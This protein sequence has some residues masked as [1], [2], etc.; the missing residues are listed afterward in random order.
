MIFLKKIHL[1]GKQKI[2]LFGFLII[3]VSLPLAVLLAK[4][5]QTYQGR[6]ASQLSNMP[7][8]YN[9]PGQGIFNCHTVAAIGPD[10]I[11]G[12]GVLVY[13]G[14]LQPQSPDRLDQNALNKLIS[15]IKSGKKV[16]LHFQ[17]YAEPTGITLDDLYPAWIRSGSDQIEWI[18]TS[19]GPFPAPWSSKYQE[20]LKQFLSLL[21]TAFE[22][23][24]VSHLVEYLEPASGGRWGTTHLWF[25]E[26]DFHNWVAASGCGRTDYT[27]FRNKFSQAVNQIIKVYA[28]SFPNYSLMMIEGGAPHGAGYNGFLKLLEKYGMRVMIKGAGLG[29]R[30]EPHCGMR[31]YILQPACSIAAGN[32]LTKCGQETWGPSID[33]AGPGHGFDPE[34]ECFGGYQEIYE[35]SLR[36][37]K[38][39]YYCFYTT[40]IQCSALGQTNRMVADYL[41]AQI[42]LMN[43]NFSSTNIEIN[44]PLQIN[45]AWRNYGSTAFVAPK[46]LGEKWLAS[47][48]KLF[49]EFVKD[50]QRV[51]Y[52]EFDVSP[53]THTWQPE[54]RRYYSYFEATNALKFNVPAVLGGENANSQNTYKVYVGF[55]DPNGESERFALI[56]QQNNDLQNRRYLLTNNFIVRGE[57]ETPTITPMPTATSSPQ[58]GLSTLTFKIKLQGVT[59]QKPQQTTQVSLTQS[60]ETKYQQD[61]ILTANGEGYYTGQIGNLTP[62][63][64]DVYVKGWAHLQKKFENIQIN[65]G[66]NE[67]VW[68]QTTLPAGD[69]NDD[70]VLDID[71]I[72]L[73]LQQYTGTSVPA[74]EENYQFDVNL[75]GQINVFDLAL[76][77]QNWTDLKVPGE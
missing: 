42:E 22:Q 26:S 40:D 69:F 37:E 35:A 41:G 60:G 72:S 50:N 16:Y 70:N 65:L 46:K 7:A 54:K 17:I 77:L 33:C 67:I 28:D 44:Q 49:L 45:F 71:D 62:G 10:Y 63:A 58:P 3:L 75:D 20:K 4:Q 59:D 47:S 19:R 76:V 30:T 9:N 1:S 64:Y 25:G 29:L 5:Q 6:A 11:K 57:G 36:E 2:T 68:T 74:N 43:F 55:T 12:G 52:Q 61:V 53:P 38:V 51:Y 73:L 31:V 39:S 14:R 32:K 48:Y 21:N 18:Q 15:Q 34:A 23:Q 56:N 66:E 8:R 27:C 24:G 13:W